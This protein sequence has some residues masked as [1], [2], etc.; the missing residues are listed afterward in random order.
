[1]NDRAQKA[2]QQLDALPGWAPAAALVADLRTAATSLRKGANLFQI[3]VKANDADGVKQAASFINSGTS[4]ITSATSE[5]SSLASQY[6][7]SCP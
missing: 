4:A 5:I 7:F 3:A 2:Q 6:G 1:V